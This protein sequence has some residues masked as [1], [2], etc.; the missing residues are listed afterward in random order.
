[1]LV[2]MLST[3]PLIWSGA[4]SHW[5]LAWLSLATL[6]PPTLYAVSQRALYK[7]WLRRLVGLPVLIC[8][9]IGL[10]L[11]GTAAALEAILGIESAF[12]RTPKY[13]ISGRS[14][15]WKNR[16]Y[17]LPNGGLLWGEILLTLYATLAV[18]AA[19]QR[20][21]VLAIPFLL[22][23]VFGFG[24]VSIVQVA[25]AGKRKRETRRRRVSQ[26]KRRSRR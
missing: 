17:T 25:Q 6:G 20:G 3:L 13:E 22:L 11:N 2:V 9:G 5:S 4:L 19:L 21:Q 23:Y 12:Q 10:A 16:S 18:V 24:Y 1:M 8:V 26:Q 7:D 15:E 14:G